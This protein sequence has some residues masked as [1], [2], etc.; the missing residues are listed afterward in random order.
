MTHVSYLRL[1]DTLERIGHTV[2]QGERQVNEP[3]LALV[4]AWSVVD[5]L[6][7]LHNVLRRFP[8]MKK[9][10]QLEVHLRA[11]AAV[12]DL[13]HGIQHLDE[14]LKTLATGQQPVLGSLSWLWTPD[15]PL[16][17][18]LMMAVAAG[19]MREGWIPMTNPGGRKFHRPIGLVTL[20]G[21]GKELDLTALVV[22]AVE[23]AKGLDQGAR[24]V[25]GNS[26]AGGADV[27][28]ALSFK[29]GSAPPNDEAAV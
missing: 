27:V 18:G 9:S 15:E 11:I 28:L 8:G 21:F 29:F 2:R 24:M 20:A 14:N 5:N 6:W 22:R 19:A 7:R 16:E 12:E 17:T 3:T 23:V 4:D 26:P 13:R 10:P 1:V 25:V